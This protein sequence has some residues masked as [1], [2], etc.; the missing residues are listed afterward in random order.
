M[1]NE[2]VQYGCGWSAAANWKNFDASPTL[3]FE[4]IPIIGKLYTKNDARFPQNVEY[5]DIVKGLPIPDNSCKGVYCSHILE[6]LSLDDFKQAIINTHKVLKSG[7]C[8]RLVLP[9]LEY[10]INKYINDSSADSASVFLK[11][12]S[13][14][15]E[16]RSRGLKGFLLEWYGNSQHLWMWDYKSIAQELENA[17][18]IDI[19]KAEYGDAT[20]T[21]FTEVEDKGRWENCLGVEC[22]KA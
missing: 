15:K 8:F 18:F 14:G 10:S 7:G 21:S 20:D 12:T 9:D 11:E 4:R 13:L 17:G 2:Y 3:R 6:H 19:R 22:K 16:K 1:N 5:G